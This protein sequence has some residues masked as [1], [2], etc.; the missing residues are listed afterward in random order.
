MG[1]PD[2]RPMQNHLLPLRPIQGEPD[3]LLLLQVA[4]RVR[5]RGARRYLR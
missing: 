1:V 5:C 2:D 4:V 3:L